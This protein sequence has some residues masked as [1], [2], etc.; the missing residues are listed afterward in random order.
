M[1]ADLVD[2]FKVVDVWVGMFISPDSFDAYLAENYVGEDQPI[3]LFASDQGQSF[4]DHDFLRAASTDPTLDPAGLLEDYVAIPGGLGVGP[5]NA[6]ILVYGMQIHVPC[7]ARGA[8]YELHYL[9]QY[10]PSVA[11]D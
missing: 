6:F 10:S 1:D 11:R 8:G 7:S 4:Y 3:S 2:T 9:G 5:V